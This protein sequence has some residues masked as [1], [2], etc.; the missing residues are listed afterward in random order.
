MIILGLL[1]WIFACAIIKL[2]WPSP[3]MFVL[4]FIS[5]LYWFDGGPAWIASGIAIGFYFGKPVSVRQALEMPM[6]H[7]IFDIIG[8]ICLIIGIVKWIF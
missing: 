8:T 5:A 3:I 4:V 1:V 2:K 7:P 6:C